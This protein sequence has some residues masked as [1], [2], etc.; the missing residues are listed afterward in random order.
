MFASLASCGSSETDRTVFEELLSVI[1][2]TPEA[3]AQVLINDYA[4]VRQLFNIPMA[5][6][7]AGDEELL[8]F[9]APHFRNVEDTGMA[10]GPFISGYH[11]FAR[12]SL[13]NRHHLAFDVRSVEQSVKAGTGYQ[14]RLDVARGPA[15]TQRL[16]ARPSTPV[17]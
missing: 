4:R 16:P 8:E 12:H 15:S 9:L 1:P 6:P 2:D 11:K 14:P 17:T 3:R 10:Q 5:P 13:R 7:D